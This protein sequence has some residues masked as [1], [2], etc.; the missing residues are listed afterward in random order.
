ML[1]F[2]AAARSAA[3]RAE[4]L[5]LITRECDAIGRQGPVILVGV[6]YIAAHRAVPA[7]EAVGPAAVFGGGGGTAGTR[8]LW[9]TWGSGRK[10]LSCASVFAYCELHY[11]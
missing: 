4:T 3:E 11:Y 7:R 10:G 5:R 9:G 2:S 6:H 1:C 8:E